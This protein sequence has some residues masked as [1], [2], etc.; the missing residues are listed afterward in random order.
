MNDA[1]GPR[2]Q[3]Q[4]GSTAI[5]FDSSFRIAIEARDVDVVEVATNAHLSRTGA[6]RLAIDPLALVSGRVSIRHIEAEKIN[7]DTSLLPA[8]EPMDLSKT[9]IDGIPVPW[10]RYSSGWMK[11]AG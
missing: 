10:S 3:A 11:R 6:L 1:I 8:S 7:L 2:Y 4:V 5:R 9:R